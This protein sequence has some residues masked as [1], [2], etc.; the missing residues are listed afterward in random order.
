MS[1]RAP[2]DTGVLRRLFISLCI[3]AA[4]ALAI[5]GASVVVHGK[6]KHIPSQPAREPVSTRAV[7]PPP[8]ALPLVL[9]ATPP[10]PSLGQPSTTTTPTATTPTTKKKPARGGSA[11][12]K[13]ARTTQPALS[14]DPG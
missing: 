3:G 13:P 9:Q 10:V 7:A 8:I 12:G 4:G 14:Q 11:K 6:L 1:A 2:Q 5:A